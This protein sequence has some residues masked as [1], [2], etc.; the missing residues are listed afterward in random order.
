MIIHV[1][2][3]PSS[4]ERMGREYFKRYTL[5]APL[6]P[7]EQGC[8]PSVYR[9]C[10]TLAPLNTKFLSR[11]TYFFSN[12]KYI[13]FVLRSTFRI[14]GLRPKILSLG[15]TQINLFFLLLMRISGLWPKILSLDKKQIKT[16]FI[17]IC[18]RLCVSLAFGRRYFRSTKSKL[19]RVLFAFV[20][21]YAYLCKEF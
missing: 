1:G 7:S 14:S 3:R 9:R 21:T 2:N 16:S 5:I 20:L 4:L 6:A 18:S 11:R 19:K 10:N 15:K 17:C 12:Y 8:K 13:F